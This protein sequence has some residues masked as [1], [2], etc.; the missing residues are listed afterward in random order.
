MTKE[1][2]FVIA[3]SYTAIR[4]TQLPLTIEYRVFTEDGDDESIA[5]K[6][7]M[8][9]DERN[10]HKATIKK[11]IITIPIGTPDGLYYYTARYKDMVSDNKI[12]IYVDQKYVPWKGKRK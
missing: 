8:I 5:K 1:K 9:E 10:P 4:G 3:P 6:I 2:K 11:N 7:E 12:T